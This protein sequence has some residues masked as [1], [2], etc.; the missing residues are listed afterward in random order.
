MPFATTQI[1]IE[2]IMPSEIHHTQR[3]KYHIISCTWVLKKIKIKTS[4]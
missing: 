1:D 4:S 3:D 2:T